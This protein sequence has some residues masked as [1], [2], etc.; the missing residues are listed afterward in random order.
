MFDRVLAGLDS[1]STRVVEIVGEPGIGKTRLLAEFRIR[2]EQRGQL[3][4]GGRATEFGRGVPFGIAIEVIDD[5]LAAL[6]ADQLQRLDPYCLDLLTVLLRS[7]AE[8]SVAPLIP[9]SYRWRRAVRTLLQALAEPHGLV[10]ALDDVHWADAASAEL[11]DH[12][13]RHPPRAPALLAVTYRPR[14]VPARLAASLASAG[15]DG[16]V[17]RIELGPLT[18]EEAREFLGPSF[19]SSSQLALYRSSGGNP[20]YLEALAAAPPG[21][22]EPAWSL[23]G[24]LACKLPPCVSVA[25]RV[26]FDVLTPIGRVVAHAAAVLGDPFEPEVVAEVA[27]VSTP[28]ALAALDDLVALDLVRPTASSQFCYRHPLVRQVVYHDAGAGWR[29]GAHVRAALALA[30]RNVSAVA[31]AVHLERAGHAGDDDSVGVL[32]E[33]AQI[34]VNRAPAAAARWLHAALRILP[35]RRGYAMRRLELLGAL[36]RALAM[37]GKLHASRSVLYEVLRLSTHSSSRHRADAVVWCAHVEPLLGRHREIRALLLAELAALPDENSIEGAMLKSGLASTSLQAGDLDPAWA[38]E[39]MDAARH[40]HDLTLRA[41]ALGMLAMAAS[42]NGDIDRACECASEARLA[43]D[44][45][46]D[47]EFA[48]R[49]NASAWIGWSEAYVECYEQALGHFSGGL[50]LAR[51]AGCGFVIPHVLVGLTS[52]YTC[53]GRLAEAA[54]CAEDAVDNAQL[55]AT[56]QLRSMAL[57]AQARVALVSGNDQI[58]RMIALRAVE[59]TGT[60]KDPWWRLSRIVLAEARLACGDPEGCVQAI[61]DAGDGPELVG[62]AAFLRVE[63]YGALVRIELAQGCDDAALRWADRA[64]AAAAALGLPGRTGFALLARAEVLAAND[65]IIAFK[66]ALAAAAAFSKTGQRLDAGRA[67]RLAGTLLAG[68]GDR[69]RAMVEFEQAATLFDLCGA[70]RLSDQV[71]REQREFGSVN[72]YEDERPSRALGLDA[73]SSREFE[74]ATLVSKG[75]TNRQI[76][77]ILS[78]SPR[79]VET[80]LERVFVKFGASSRAEVASRIGPALAGS[81]S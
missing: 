48:Q 32:A 69:R 28:E 30:A 31:R 54:A 34:M 61:V 81:S 72:R 59:A 77:R 18:V 56:D 45:L 11:L 70:R 29:L 39:A 76:A 27:G 19:S 51:Q 6:D 1:M 8:G 42:V 7:A 24:T 52:V 57:T 80:Y 23:G 50:C 49:L 55:L 62:I 60:V 5:C 75:L 33:A 14:Q 38:E 47:D 74:V 66:H 65:A 9:A 20:L 22:H 21:M 26:G 25:L 73:L 58:A 63:V 37:A 43:L 3:V 40:H 15:S 2:A 64:E 44:K 36:G 46:P 17:E 16:F 4:L 10:I 67:H 68:A 71:R 53:L 41:Y 13:F 78:L 79:T 12:L 35:D